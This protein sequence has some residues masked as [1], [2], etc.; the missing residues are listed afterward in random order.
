MGAAQNLQDLDTRMRKVFD[1]CRERNIKLNP[2]NLQC[3]KKV[4]FGG[5]LIEASKTAGETKD[6]VYIS[7]DQHKID[8]FL[9]IWCVE[10]RHS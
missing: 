4:K 2:R 6:T 8:D 3:G 9:D 7:P 10:Q 5:M 1:V